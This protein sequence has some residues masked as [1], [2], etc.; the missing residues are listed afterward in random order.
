VSER[1]DNRRLLVPA[2]NYLR[3]NETVAV[4]RLRL[5]RLLNPELLQASTTMSE[6]A[7][8]PTNAT[9][10]MVACIDCESQKIVHDT[11]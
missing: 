4:A 8:N 2:Y 10:E 9:T 6:L 5:V 11:S 7:P 3:H 1:E